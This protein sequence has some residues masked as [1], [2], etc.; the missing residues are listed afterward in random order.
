[1]DPHVNAAR[2]HH[3]SQGVVKGPRSGLP[4]AQERRGKKCRT[5][6]PA[7]EAAAARKAKGERARCKGLRP[8]PSEHRLDEPVDEERLGPKECGRPRRAPPAKARSPALERSQD[9]PDK[10]VLA[11]RAGAVHEEVHGFPA[12]QVSLEERIHGFVEARYRR[13][14]IKPRADRRAFSA[15]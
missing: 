6:V 3:E 7:R 13:K 9:K 14:L 8:A 15:R 11:G 10:A 2:T 5:G 12:P 4:P 1:M